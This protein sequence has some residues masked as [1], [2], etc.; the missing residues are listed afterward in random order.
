[1][2]NQDI[3]RHFSSVLDFGANACNLAHAITR[4]SPPLTARIS[5][6]VSADSSPTLLH[7]DASLPYNDLLNNHTRTVLPIPDTAPLPFLPASFSAA[8]SSLSMHWINDLPSALAQINRI[9]KPDS[10]FLAAMLGGDSL[11]ELRTSLQLADLDRRGGVSTHTSPLADVRDMGSL[12]T[13]AG[14]NLLT[15]DVDDVIVDYPSSFALMMDLQAMGEGNAVL[16]G[17]GAGAL[18][19]EVLLAMDGIYRELHGNN[20]GTVPATF[21][22]IFMIGWTGGEGQAR[23][24]KRG[25]GK[26]SMKDVLEDVRG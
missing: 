4:S 17:G 8:I 7:R 13:K 22:V 21:R 12:L 16:G 15:V 20:D 6:L 25:S 2:Q 10:P 1:M 23:P 26:I 11:Y 24:L 5:S 3:N 9:L 19:R 18:S 14:F